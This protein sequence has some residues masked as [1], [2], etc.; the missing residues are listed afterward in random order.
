MT[1]FG[2]LTLSLPTRRYVPPGVGWAP[3]TAFLIA[4]AHQRVNSSFRNAMVT[5]DLSHPIERDAKL[6]DKAAIE[7]LCEAAPETFPGAVIKDWTGVLDAGGR[8]IPF[9]VDACRDLL[10]QLL[11]L[12]KSNTIDILLDLV[13]FAITVDPGDASKH[14]ESLVGNC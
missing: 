9:T 13:E 12:H 8:P 4:P 7:R 1:T 10:T 2:H 6:T 11:A 3:D 14:V 5:F